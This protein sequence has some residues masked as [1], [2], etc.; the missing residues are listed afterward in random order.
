MLAIII[1]YYKYSY[2]KTTLDSLSNQTYKRFKVYIGD[3]ASQESPI[4]VLQEYK[5]KFDFTYFRFE[6]NIGEKSLTQ[7]WQRC[8]TLS[9]NEEW[10]MILGDDDY[11]SENAVFSF[12]ENYNSFKDDCNVVRFTTTIINEINGIKSEVFLNPTF[13]SG[14]EYISRKLKGLTRGSL[15]EFVFKKSEFFKCNFT[16]Y[17]SAFYSDDKIVLDLT[18]TKKIYSIN[19]AIIFVRV[20][21]ESLSGKAEQIGGDFFLA[22]VCFFDYLFREK[23]FFLDV[24]LQKIVIERLLSYMSQVKEYNGIVFFKIYLRSLMF[25]NFN[26]FLKINIK[27]IKI[28]LGKSID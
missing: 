7:Q 5:G 9:G 18:M 23:Y 10:F 27:I 1:P 16:H 17:P 22:R 13:E 21:S 26:F 8:L 15:S 19:D 20:S 24:D 4:D 11:L 2:F 12:Y 6:H 14:I 3:D 25:L 28:I